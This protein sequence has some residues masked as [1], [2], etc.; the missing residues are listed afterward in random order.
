MT[1]SVD[2]KNLAIEQLKAQK[3]KGADAEAFDAARPLHAADDDLLAAIAELDDTTLDA[4]MEAD[5]PEGIVVPRVTDKQFLLRLLSREDEVAQAKRPGQ[6]A[7][8]ALQCM[9]QA[10]EVLRPTTPWQARH[11]DPSAFGAAEH[12]IKRR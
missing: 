10:A 7:R 5:V 4:P 1:L 8:E 6:G 2:A 12:E 3:K 9:R 11:E